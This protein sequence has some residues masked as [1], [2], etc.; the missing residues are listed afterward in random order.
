MDA[1]TGE[2]QKEKEKEKEY[3]ALALKTMIKI[4]T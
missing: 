2:F 3:T 4:G 1:Y